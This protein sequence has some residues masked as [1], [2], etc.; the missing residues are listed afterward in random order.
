MGAT[1]SG[2]FA[3]AREAGI[4]LERGATVLGSQTAGT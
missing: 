4:E 2:V 1:E 3:L